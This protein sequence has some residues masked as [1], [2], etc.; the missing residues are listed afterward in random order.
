MFCWLI[1]L[2]FVWEGERYERG[3]WRLLGQQATGYKGSVF[4]DDMSRMTKI[5]EK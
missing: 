4:K 2:C 3:V 5:K 1:G